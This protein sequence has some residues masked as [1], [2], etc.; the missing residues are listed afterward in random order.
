MLI[1]SNKNAGT[2][3]LTLNLTLDEFCK[4]AM[5]GGYF[6]G[7]NHFKRHELTMMRHPGTAA[8]TQNHAQIGIKQALQQS[9]EREFPARYEQAVVADDA[10]K[11]TKY[12]ITYQWLNVW[13]EKGSW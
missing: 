9:Y 12:K 13:R 4:A 7:E 2:F 10:P 6:I 1:Y 5:L 8:I 11:S 3:Q